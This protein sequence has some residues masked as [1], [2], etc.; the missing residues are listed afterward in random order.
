MRAGIMARVSTEEQLAGYSIGAQVDAMLKFCEEQGWQVMERYIEEGVSGTTS[1][2]PE[3][4]RALRDAEAGKLDVLLTHQLDRFYRNLRLQI[5]TLGKLG[6]MGVGYLSI[7][8]RID[9]STPTGMLFMQMLGAFNEYYSSNLARE[10]RKGKQGRAESGLT[11][12]TFLPHGYKRVEK[13]AVIEPVRAETIHYIFK[14]YATGLYSYRAIADR[15]NAEGHP[16][17][18]RSKGKWIWQA[19]RGIIE[20]PYYIGLIRHNEKMYQG[21][22]EPIIER[23]LWDMAQRVREQ[24]ATSYTHSRTKETFILRG[25]GH[26]LACGSRLYAESHGKNRYYRCSG[27]QKGVSCTVPFARVEK[28]D[29]SLA[30]L[31]SHAQLPGNWREEIARAMQGPVSNDGNKRKYLQEKLRRLRELYLEDDFTKE[32]YNQ[33]KR[34]LESEIA[35]LQP[36]GK[37]DDIDAELIANLSKLWEG[38]ELQQRTDLA[39]ILFRSVEVD[40]Q[41]ERVVSFESYP[42]HAMLFRLIFEEREGKF[43]NG[44]A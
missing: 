14:L 22:H 19:V 17:S 10:V 9:Y 4:Q 28:V 35:R 31:V 41:E 26:C 36:P 27:N 3:L 24:R 8:E 29:A 13:E 15:L 6:E 33:R 5:E 42:E 7:T 34:E 18:S 11:N 1:N 12:A 44:Q 21:K 16:A 23:K 38:A 20:N 32:E 2:R 37:P 40:M 30:E 25:T 39:N 43:Y